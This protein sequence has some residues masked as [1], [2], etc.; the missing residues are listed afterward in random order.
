[1]PVLGLEGAGKC[2]IDVRGDGHGAAV[3]H[4]SYRRLSG[5]GYRMGR[6]HPR[7]IQPQGDV[8]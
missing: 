5:G 2:G 4:C 3:W 7:G 8:V 1:M 6:C